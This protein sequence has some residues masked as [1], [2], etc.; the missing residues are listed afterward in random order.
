MSFKMDLKLA[1]ASEIKAN[2]IKISEVNE[3]A[4][5]FYENERIVWASELNPLYEKL[6]CREFSELTEL[7]AIN[8]SF[9]HRIQDSITHYLTRLSKEHVRFK[10][11]FGDRMEFYAENYANKINT[12]EKVKLVER[13]LNERK[14]AMELLEAHI[15]H[16][17]E[18]RTICD[19]IQYSVKNITALIG[20]S[21]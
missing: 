2:N 1:K 18:L 17:K 20:Y 19:Q 7:Q 11:N 5:E 12:T 4:K 14:H 9:R 6:K 21:S 16:L 3:K 13:D 15:E 8:L 10:Q